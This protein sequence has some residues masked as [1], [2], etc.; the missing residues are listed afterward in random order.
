MFPVDPDLAN[1]VVVEERAAWLL[2]VRAVHQVCVAGVLRRCKLGVPYLRKGRVSDPA[3][4]RL[5]KTTAGV[6]CASRISLW[7]GNG[8]THVP[9]VEALRMSVVKPLW[10]RS[11]PVYSNNTAASGGGL[12]AGDY[13][14]SADGIVRQL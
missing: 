11:L 13:Y 4:F 1:H 3:E 9:N 10:T 2:V 14:K 7:I 8:T 6:S 5:G 12:I